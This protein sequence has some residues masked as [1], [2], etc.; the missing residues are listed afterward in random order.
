MQTKSKPKSKTKQDNQSN[1]FEN[2]IEFARK[3]VNVPKKEIDEQEEKYQMR[4]S[5][6]KAKD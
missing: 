4:K 1:E 3:I 2:F 6:E 5:R